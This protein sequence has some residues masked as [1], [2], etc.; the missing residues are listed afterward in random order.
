MLDLLLDILGRTV[1]ANRVSTIFALSKSDSVA[2]VDTVDI[3]AIY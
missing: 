1:T 2:S 3:I